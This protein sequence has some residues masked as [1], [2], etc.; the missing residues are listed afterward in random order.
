MIV[1]GVRVLP[2]L[3]SCIHRS[4]QFHI[5]V[6]MRRLSLSKGDGRCPTPVL[7]HKATMADMESGRNLGD[8]TPEGH[9]GV[10]LK[11]RFKFTPVQDALDSPMVV[12]T[13]RPGLPRPG[14]WQPPSPGLEQ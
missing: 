3:G 6:A 7:D 2:Q 11:P 14:H 8:L 4:K 12:T 9:P 13:W 1:P 10:P 5:L